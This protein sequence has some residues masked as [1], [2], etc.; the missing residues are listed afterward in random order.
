MFFCRSVEIYFLVE[1]ATQMNIASQIRK[2]PRYSSYTSSIPPLPPSTTASFA[3]R[4]PHPKFISNLSYNFI[5][6]ILRLAPGYRDRGVW[7]RLSALSGFLYGQLKRIIAVK[8]PPALGL[9]EDSL[10][11]EATY[12]LFSIHACDVC[13]RSS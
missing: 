9:E 8:L 4:T 13:R 2:A 11:A 3:V 12:S 10:Y 1:V 7:L 5:S 6:F